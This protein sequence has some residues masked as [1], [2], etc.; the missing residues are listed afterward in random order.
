MTQCPVSMPRKTKLVT[1]FSV[2][3]DFA[4]LARRAS[5]MGI[6]AAAA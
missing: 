3:R 1:Q 2:F 6:H 4:L 5:K